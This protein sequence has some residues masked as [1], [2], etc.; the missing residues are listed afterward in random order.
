VPPAPLPPALSIPKPKPMTLKVGKWKTVK[1]RVTN[2]GGTDAVQGSLR[3]KAPKGVLVKPEKQQLPTLAPG[4][5]WTVSLRLELTK[6]AKEKSTL[7]FTGTAAGAVTATGSF[8]LKLKPETN[9]PPVRP[10]PKRLAEGPVEPQAG[11]W[12]G[13]TKQGFPVYFRV[14]NGAVTNIRVTYRDAIC[15]KATIHEATGSLGI[16]ESGYFAGVIYPAN[17]GVEL[18]G[19]VTGPRSIKGKIVAGESS[20]LPGCLGGSFSFTAHP[21]T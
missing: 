14:A 3:I 16:D 4:A 7:T 20:G 17:G 6:K 8:V 15:G 5:S 18:E 2:T 13:K 12:K 9:A 11:A 19:T 21:K 10:A 1:I